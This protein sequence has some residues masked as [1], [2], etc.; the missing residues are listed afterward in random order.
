MSKA[1]PQRPSSAHHLA[2]WSAR[3]TDGAERDFLLFELSRDDGA[4]LVVEVS[5]KSAHAIQR[6]R[7]GGVSYRTFAGVTP[8]EAVELTKAFAEQLEAGEVDVTPA[9]PKPVVHPPRPTPTSEADLAVHRF[10]LESSGYTV[11]PSILD[12]RHVDA[13]RLTAGQALAAT[14]RQVG[15]GAKIPPEAIEHA[16][17]PVAR[18]VEG[19]EGLRHLAFPVAVRIERT[20]QADQAHLGEVV[21]EV[22]MGGKH[23]VAQGA[24]RRDRQRLGH[25]GAIR[26]QPVLQCLVG[27]LHHRRDRPQGVVQVQRDRGNLHRAS[28]RP[29][30]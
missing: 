17:H 23:L 21:A 14:Q 22:R 4:R 29:G 11:V 19:L 13:L 10:A 8:A 12:P 18:G 26:R 9:A 6:V 25:V 7:L 5:P 3:R 15:L 28:L 1:D 27:A 30:A 24:H 16:I 2:G 20:A